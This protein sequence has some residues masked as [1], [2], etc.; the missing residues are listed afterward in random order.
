VQD[1]RYRGVDIPLSESLQD[2]A[3]RVLSYWNDAV[4]PDVRAGRNVSTYS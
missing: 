2:T 1:A 3:E 4:L